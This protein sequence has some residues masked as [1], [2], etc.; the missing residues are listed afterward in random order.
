MAEAVLVTGGA[1]YVGSHTCK[2]LASRGYLPVSLDNLVYGH[3]WAAQWGPLIQG[4]IKDSPVLDQILADYR[5]I[6]IIH[7]A[8]YAYVGESVEH[9]AKYYENNV[10]GSISL[11][12]AMRR[13]GC[14]NIIFSSSCSTY[15]IPEQIP[16]PEDHPQRP[17]NPYGRS[18]LMMEQIIK[19][20]G[21]AYGIRYAIL[22]YF[23]AA[24]GDPEGKI[25]ESHDPETHL[26]PILLQTVLGR[27]ECTEVYGTDYDTPDG[28]AI[29]DYIHVTDLGVAHVLALKHLAGL[30]QSLCLNLGTGRG[31]SV[32]EVLRAVEEV[33]G[34]RVA[35]RTMGRR[36]GDPPSLVAD[37]AQ[38]AAILGWKPDFTDIRAIVSTA[39]NWHRSQL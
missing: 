24:G 28:T 9:P 25:G 21:N 14:K 36:P 2:V 19:D 4:D 30:G 5:P 33:T 3:P 17:I 11:L 26:I 20:Y 27:R 22:R 31:C 7:F 38:A 18:K 15:G 1:G 39:W 32:M 13:N 29:R 6:A 37:A 16:I 23:N 10:G 8:A 12:E 34:K 35:Y